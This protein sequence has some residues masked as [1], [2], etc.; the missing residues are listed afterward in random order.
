MLNHKLIDNTIVI[1][2]ETLRI[3]N[4]LIGPKF[5]PLI[6][7]EIGIN[8]NGDLKKA[9]QMIRDAYHAGAECVKF[10]CHIIEDEM[11]PN[12]IVPINAKESIWNIMKKCSFS[13][14]Q[15]IELKK[16]TEKFKMIYISTPFSRAAADRLERMEVSAYKIGSGECNNFPLIKHIARFGKPMIVSTGMN[17]IKSIKKTVKILENYSINYAILH[18]TSMYPTPYDKVRLESITELKKEFPNIVLGLSDHSIGN[19]ICY[20]TISLGAS[21]LEKHFTS[22]KKWRGPDIPISIDK[23]EL[24]ELIY[25]SNAIHKALK[26]KKVIL[27]E[28]QPTINFAYAC[29]VSIS[30]IKKGEQITKKNVWVKRPGTGEIKASEYY[31]ILN[32]KALKSIPKNSQLRWNEIE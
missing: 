16:Y 15:E 31:K 18:V 6:I 25:G 22:N 7:P 2:K 27:P 3:Q 29:V 1:M 26:G 30:N 20:A 11:I 19:Y 28:E 4:R 10:Q 9:K 12:D 17:D 32:K 21:I 24:K 23:L 5:K 13:E 14:E 8:H